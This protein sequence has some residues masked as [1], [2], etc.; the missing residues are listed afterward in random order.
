MIET[1]MISHTSVNV[2]MDMPLRRFI[3]FRNA[4]ANVLERRENMPTQ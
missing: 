2:Y 3:K 1:A 4:L